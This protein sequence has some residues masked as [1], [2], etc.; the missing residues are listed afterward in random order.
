MDLRAWLDGRSFAL[1]R[2]LNCVRDGVFDGHEVSPELLKRARENTERIKEN[3]RRLSEKSRQYAEKYKQEAEE[4]QKEIQQRMLG[5]QKSFQEKMKEIQETQQNSWGLKNFR[6]SGSLKTFIE[7][8]LSEDG[9][10]KNGETKYTFELT[11]DKLSI[12]DKEQ[13]KAVHKKYLKL[14]R[15]HTNMDSTDYDFSVKFYDK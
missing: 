4:R 10:L 13:S 3:A 14:Y 8:H 15:K 1:A 11:N 7:K 12:N 9:F 6:Q 5:E 2:H